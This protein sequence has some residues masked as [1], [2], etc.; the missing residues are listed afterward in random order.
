M[1]EVILYNL[2]REV[3]EAEYEKYCQRKKG[4]FCYRDKDLVD[5]GGY[6]LGHKY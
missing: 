5:E 2:K 1:K 3:S 4:P 6:R